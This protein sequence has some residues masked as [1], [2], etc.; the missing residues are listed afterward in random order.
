MKNIEIR[1]LMDIRFMS[2]PR[3]SPDGAYTAYVVSKQNEAENRY[4]SW[5][6]LL[7]QLSTGASRQL[8]FSGQR[9]RFCLGGRAARCCSPPSA[10]TRT[11]RRSSAEKDLLLP[12]PGPTAA[13][14]ARRSSCR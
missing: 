5:L 11:S 3:I 14:R 2:N 1:D 8:T 4:E 7:R 12:P 6:W 13:R 10:A 9:G